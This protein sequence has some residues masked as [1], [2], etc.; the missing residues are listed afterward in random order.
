VIERDILKPFVFERGNIRGELV[1]LDESWRTAAAGRGYPREV[2]DLLGELMA[3]AALL[4]AMLK[5]SGALVAQ[6]QGDGKVPLLVVECTSELTLRGMAQWRDSVQA[7]PLREL[8][9]DGRFAITL[10]PRDGRQSYQG[11]VELRGDSIAEALEHYMHRSEQLAT[12]LWLA[13]D[14]RQ[15]AGM[16][17]Q[18]L[19]DAPRAD[20]DAW[21]R[22]SALGATLT[23]DEL[24][25]LAPAELLRR[26]FHEEDVRVF[27]SRPLAFRCSC[28]VERVRSMLRMMGPDEIRE[29][30]AE[31]GE[32]EVH[33][34][35][36]SRRYALD[37][38]DAE[39]LFA[40][41]HVNEAGRTRH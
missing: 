32:V 20:E 28:S 12:R 16:L 35:F 14:E 30:V 5:F 27:A 38:F 34:E 7:A 41:E 21:E 8:V 13:A 25:T 9:G 17:L 1:R 6:I 2:R 33:C 4:S 3:A 24:L 37:A 31:R 18:R 36:C 10:D 19:P 26:L 11:I 22:V 40:A 29:I 15:A 39:Q 23:R